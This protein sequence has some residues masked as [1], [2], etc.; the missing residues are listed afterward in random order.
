MKIDPTSRT[1]SD[2]LRQMARKPLRWPSPAS[3]GGLVEAF[4][5]GRARFGTLSVCDTDFVPNLWAMPA[6]LVARRDADHR[7]V[8]VPA[9]HAAEEERVALAEHAT[10]GGA[11]PVALPACRRGEADHRRA[12]TS[13]WILGPRRFPP[14]WPRSQ[15]NGPLP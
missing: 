14:S 15:C 11:E 6:W 9:A 8:E 2:E 5:R 10:V 13:N 4:S 12:S 1:N 7:L 3:S